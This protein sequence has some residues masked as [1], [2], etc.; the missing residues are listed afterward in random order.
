MT[1][2]DATTPPRYVTAFRQRLI[3]TLLCRHPPWQ[4]RDVMRRHGVTT[5]GP[6]PR[7][8]KKAPCGP[9][10][11]KKQTG[12]GGWVIVFGDRPGR[13]FAPLVA[14]LGTLSAISVSEVE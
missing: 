5:D 7:L 4:N 2:C 3:T 12:C 11:I 1:P 6:Y 10:A 8:K 14:A 9:W 13:A